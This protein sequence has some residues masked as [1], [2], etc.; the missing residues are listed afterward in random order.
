MKT[1]ILLA[2]VLLLVIAQF[3]RPAKNLSAAPSPNDITALH[4]TPPEVKTILAKACYDCHSDN[5]RYPWYN[6]IQPVGWWLANHVND[7]KR[8]LNFSQF[9]A[10]PPKRAANKLKE[11]IEL[12]EKHEMPLAS[13]T[14]IH[15]DA[16]LTDAERAALIAWAKDVARQIPPAQP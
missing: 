5:T 16:R 15:G 1:K 2:I 7:G 10:Y 3:I 8:H 13:Y 12:V 14:L 6:H 9:G 4:P 11:T